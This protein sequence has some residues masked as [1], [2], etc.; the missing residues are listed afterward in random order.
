MHLE[1]IHFPASLT[2]IYGHMT[3]FWPLGSK[4]KWGGGGGGG[5]G[6]FSYFVVLGLNMG[7]MVGP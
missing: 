1:E 7:V 5:H 4:Y 2:A 3:K 6:F